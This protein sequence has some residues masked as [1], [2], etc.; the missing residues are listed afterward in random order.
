MKMLLYA[1]LGAWFSGLVITQAFQGDWVVSATLLPLAIFSLY[2]WQD[3][4]SY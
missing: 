3:A 4:M 1:F 2:K